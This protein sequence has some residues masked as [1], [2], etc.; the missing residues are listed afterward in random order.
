[1][2]HDAWFLIGISKQ[3]EKLER[4]YCG[5]FESSSFSRHPSSAFF[6]Q[7]ENTYFWKFKQLTGSE[8]NE[9]HDSLLKIGIFGHWQN[10]E[11]IF[12][13]SHFYRFQ[14][15]QIRKIVKKCFLE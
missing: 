14:L 8:F 4:V 1:M 3:L 10:L 2:E 11:S 13:F 9:E 15:S 12:H 7:F 6:N 5:P